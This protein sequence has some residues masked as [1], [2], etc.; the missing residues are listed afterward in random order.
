[1]PRSRIVAAYEKTQEQIKSVARRQMQA[2]G[3]AGLSLRAIARELG[4]SAP[5]L[6]RYY[7]SLDALI[8]A[9]ILDAFHALADALEAAEAT[10]P[11][12]EPRGQLRA[13]LLA[14][15]EWALAHPTDFELIYGNPIPGYSA[16]AEQTVPAASRALAI[17]GRITD[18]GVRSG[19]IRLTPALT[20]I[21]ESVNAHLSLLAPGYGTSAEV[22][23]TC[24]IGW[25][26]IH[27][28]IQLE[29]FGHTPPVVG[30]PTAFYGG[31]VEALIDGG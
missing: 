7:P 16:P 17:L 26:R 27:G 19:H 21:P 10:F 8:T 29:L 2:Q 13:A 11:D 3:T 6:Y 28:A 24:M 1:M 23:H 15:R 5:A 9:L 20:T 14:Y 18:R 22:L 31:L 30:D 25:T 4:V 12:E